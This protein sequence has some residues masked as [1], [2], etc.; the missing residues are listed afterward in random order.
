MPSTFYGF[1][2]AR[3]GLVTSQLGLNITG[4][5]I[6][7]RNT[8]GYT[9]QSADIQ[10]VKSYGY[11]NS[12]GLG[13]SNIGGGSVVE[14][15]RQTRD[16]FLDRQLRDELSKYNQ[17]SVK[18]NILLEI[19]DTFAPAEESSIASSYQNF[20]DSLQDFS[21][22]SGASSMP[23]RE[24]LR[25][26]AMSFI[27]SLNSAYNRLVERQKDADD[28]IHSNV[29]RI[30]VIA[31]NIADLNE[32]I[33][34]YEL[35]GG[36]ANDLM[37]KRN[38][39]IDELASLTDIS[40]QTE[41]GKN[42]KNKVTVTIGGEKLV[43][44]TGDKSAAKKLFIEH[45]G[46]NYADGNGKKAVI[47]W[48]DANG[49]NVNISAGSIKGYLDLRD[50]DSESNFGI[51]IMIDKLDAFASKVVS[52]V[53]DIHSKG[54]TLPVGNP[55]KSQTGINFFNPNGT[56]AGTISLS[57]EIKKDVSYI[58]ASSAEVVNGSITDP[59]KQTNSG[60][61]KNLLEIISALNKEHTGL[62]ASS[63]S[64]EEY[65]IQFTSLLGGACSNATAK[66]EN[67]Y[68]LVSDYV[69]K[70]ESLSG[71]SIDEEAQNLIKFQKSYS[72]AARMIT[73][74]DEMLDVLINKTGVVGR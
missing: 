53:N 8:A 10:S 3:T 23:A 51:E 15:V 40:V 32:Q 50:G 24:D 26:S 65:I 46:G 70:R 21:A 41:T 74:M 4:H 47:K 52:V 69:N 17:W 29:D 60:Q 39:L 62:A 59:S 16:K 44:A 11:L 14:R 64:F 45:T 55:A 1:E 58:A 27:D 36:D 43:D 33:F 28:S 38:L 13:Q 20:L 30:N 73:A 18:E 31:D 37:D 57:D 71:V 67:E 5:N 6:S 22:G 9:R 61:N 42:N 35:S 56:T 63:V 54:Y 66:A 72:A 25:Q 7:N 12:A 48:G 68:T 34:R 2:I 49:A 19:E